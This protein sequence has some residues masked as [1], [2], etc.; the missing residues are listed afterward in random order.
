M[1]LRICVTLLITHPSNSKARL[2]F[3]SP[4]RKQVIQRIPLAGASG[5]CLRKAARAKKKT[6]VVGHPEVFDHVGLLVNEPPGTAGLPF[7]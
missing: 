3:T 7:I 4:Q 1:A 2:F 5:F 6:D